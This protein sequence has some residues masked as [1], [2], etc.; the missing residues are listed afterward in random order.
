[1][2][3][4]Y[5]VAMPSGW[6]FHTG[7]TIN[8]RENIGKVVKCPTGTANYNGYQL[9]TESVIHAS[10]KAIDALSY[11][12]SFGKIPCS[13][14]VVEGK[15]VVEDETKAG[16][17]SFKV[18]EEVAEADFDRCFGLK[19]QEVLHP[20]D[21]RKVEFASSI[22]AELTELKQWASVRASVWDSVRA[23]VWD[24][25]WASVRDSVWASVRDSVWASVRDSVRDSVWASVW[26]S[27]AA[28]I[29]SL[30]TGVKKW[31]YTKKVKVKGYPFQPC[32]NLIKKGLIP[33]TDYDGNWWL[34][35]FRNEKAQVMWKGRLDGREVVE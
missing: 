23:S 31:K 27:E 12:L 7:K 19:Y 17:A 6:D 3:T 33:I 35:G 20:F 18:I 14:Y 28:Y 2:K 16:F 4:Y 9:C 15:P 5:K 34:I 13:L 29:G 24:S 8:Y 32:V 22:E 26:D 10:L 21:P 25:V 1:M 30:F 11:A